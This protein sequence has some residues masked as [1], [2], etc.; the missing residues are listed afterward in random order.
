MHWIQKALALALTLSW[1]FLLT[2][3]GGASADDELD[4]LMGGFDDDFD[5]SEIGSSPSTGCGR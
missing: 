5:A 2:L 1:A 3:S 4:D